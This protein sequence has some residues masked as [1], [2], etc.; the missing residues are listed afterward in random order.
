MTAPTLSR[1][2]SW[3]PERDSANPRMVRDHLDAVG[4]WHSVWRRT[5]LVVGVLVYLAAPMVFS[6]FQLSVLDYA[7]IAAVGAIGLNVLTG[8]TGQISLGH[9]FFLGAGA[10]DH[11]IPAAVWDLATRGEYYSAYTP[12]Q[13]EASQG[14]LQTIFEW[15]TMIASLAGVEV[16]K[17]VHFF[18]ME[19]ASRDPLPLDGEMQRVY[20]CPIEQAAA[21]LTF[22]TEQRVVNRARDH[23]AGGAAD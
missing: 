17:V 5:G 19:A 16:A 21:R 1:I 11:H 9:G 20:W 8:Y 14:T 12:Y 4:L 3:L 7:G 22:E 15:Q 13:A 2:P 6:D 18:L 10:Y 23:I